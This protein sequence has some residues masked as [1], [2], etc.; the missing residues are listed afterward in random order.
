MRLSE[1]I[2]ENRVFI[3]AE[4]SANHNH[5]MEV[6]KKT[7]K[8]IKRSGADAIKLQTY[9][10]ET[11]TL[12]LDLPLFKARKGSLWEGR[13]LFDL[14]REA[15]L[16]W[17]WHA[18]IFSLAREEGLYCFSSPF[19]K[20]AT[21][22]LEQ[23]DPPA[24]KIASFEI[25]DIPLIEHV[26]EKMKPI[27][28]STGCAELADIQLAV[29]TCRK[30]GNSQIALLK[31]T[32]QYPA[33]AETMNLKTIPIMRDLFNVVVGLSDHTIGSTA[34]VVAVSLGARI[35][36]KHFTLDRNLGGPDAAFSMEPA[37]FAAMVKAVREAEASLGRI[38]Y[39]VSEETKLR[40]RSLFAVED[41]RAGEEF[42]EE[43]IRPVR[44]GHGLHP[45]HYKKILGKTAR[46]AIGKGE[47][48]S[49]TMIEDH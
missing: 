21:D 6:I 15:H 19:D 45:K 49:W 14:Y 46:T 44:P 12:N 43:N 16:P 25:T 42:T 33:P 36:E 1:L 9:L 8:A 20:S 32:S 24:Y 5:D 18:E 30:V 35:I 31:C 13:A 10:P 39:Q 28:L 22:F 23:F 26:A 38:T 37:E 29:D 4:L 27:I 11:M 40:R 41:I 3:I 34:P 48:L 7:V 47:P 17:E 2:L